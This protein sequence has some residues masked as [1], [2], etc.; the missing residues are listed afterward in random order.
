L[1]LEKNASKI[2]YINYNQDAT[3]VNLGHI[4]GFSLLSLNNINEFEEIFYFCCPNVFI[5]ERLFSSGLVC[6]ASLND[7]MSLQL[8]HFKLKS[9]ICKLK[10]ADPIICVKINRMR[11]CVITVKV[12]YIYDFK[13]MQILSKTGHVAIY[14]LNVVT[15][16]NEGLAHQSNISALEFNKSANLLCTSSIK[17]TLVRVFSIP[18]LKLLHEFR[19]S[20]LHWYGIQ[21]LYFSPDSRFISCAGKSDTIHVIELTKTGFEKEF[22]KNKYFL[23]SLYDNIK[24]LENKFTLFSD[25]FSINNFEATTKFIADIKLPYTGL[26]N[27]CAIN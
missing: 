25:P 15:K 5:V 24:N 11:L 22:L 20:F 9:H 27:I 13:D 8:Y 17:G 21:S 6:F 19:R 2:L 4:H 23:Y 12:L 14:D 16:I 18:D 1:K 26:K 10:H 7:P 3:S